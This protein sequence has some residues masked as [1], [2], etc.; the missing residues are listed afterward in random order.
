[1]SA[2]FRVLASLASCLAMFTM[3][4]SAAELS[5]R[6][7]AASYQSPHHHHHWRPRYWALRAPSEFIAGVRGASPLTV[8]FFGGRWVPG[9]AF[10]YPPPRPCCYYDPEPV[11]SVMY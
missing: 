3:T 1:M 8:P 7:F 9:P 11:I 2:P 5:N 6:P 4:A 10:Y